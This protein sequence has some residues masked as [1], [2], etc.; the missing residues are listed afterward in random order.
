MD[1]TAKVVKYGHAA[2]IQQYRKAGDDKE[3]STLDSKDSL[4]ACQVVFAAVQNVFATLHH[5]RLLIRFDA[6][7][8]FLTGGE[9]DEFIQRPLGLDQISVKPGLIDADVKI[10]AKLFITGRASMFVVKAANPGEFVI[11]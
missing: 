8:Y 9:V 2:Q 1:Q 7:T 10:Q 3:D 11:L 5:I 4:T 6:A